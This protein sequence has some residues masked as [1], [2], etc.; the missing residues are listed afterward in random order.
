M[1]DERKAIAKAL[2]EFD[3]YRLEQ[4]VD[5]IVAA[6]T[7][8]GFKILPREP[9]EAM[10]FAGTQEVPTWDYEANTRKYQAMWDAYLPPPPNPQGE[11]G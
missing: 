3:G 8:A 9:T 1:S 10:K 6:L 2:W 5:A 7:V 4:G 11:R